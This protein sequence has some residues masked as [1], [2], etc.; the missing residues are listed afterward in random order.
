MRAINDIIT[1]LRKP[2]GQLIFIAFFYE[3]IIFYVIWIMQKIPHLSFFVPYIVPTV[4]LFLL[5]ATKNTTILKTN[6]RLS[7]T[8]FVPAVFISVLISYLVHPNTQ[9]IIGDRYIN[10]LLFKCIPYFFVGLLLKTDDDT[11]DF[12]GRMSEI[13]LVIGIA[14]LYY[15]LNISSSNVIGN[16]NMSLAYSYMFV[17]M[18]CIIYAFRR[19][20]ISAWIMSGVGFI[21]IFMLGT[22]GPVVLVAAFLI[23]CIAKQIVQDKQKRT[24]LLI[25]SVAALVG[26]CLFY[27]VI[28]QIFIV[29]T[30][31]AGL[32]TRV[33]DKL[34][35]H[36]LLQSTARSDMIDLL[37]EKIAER[38][39]LGYGIAGEWQ[40]LDWN[41]HNMYMSFL[42]QFGVIIGSIL[43]VCLVWMTC[44][45]YKSSK[46]DNEK[47]ILIMFACMVFP[48]GFFGNE[49]LSMEVF[50]LVGYCM[51]QLA[52]RNEVSPD[53]RIG[54]GE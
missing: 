45:A 7:T 23:L 33:F 48:K 13:S 22:R 38:P 39:I 44:K 12:L 21:M 46:N 11:L 41:A 5:F 30:T 28:I 32:S 17:E 51:N 6:I 37:L 19:N 50:L 53:I 43:I 25:I 10:I 9:E 1:Y 31:K 20:K 29:L 2:Y 24:V 35:S 52:R 49:P 15:M 14:Y 40:F 4:V 8:L 18:L 36:N 54:S 26:I 3:T 42:V 34:L 16:D 47:Y 27:D